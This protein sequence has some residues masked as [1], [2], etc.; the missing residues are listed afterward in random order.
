MAIVNANRVENVQSL[1]RGMEILKAFNRD[2]PRLTLT[3]VAAITGLTRATARRFLI[4][5]TNM[6]YVGNQNRYFYLRPKILELG[7]SY[8]SSLSFND[9]VQQHL[10]VLAEELHESVSA[11]VLEFPDIVYVARASTNRVMTIG[12]SVG[13]KLPAFYTSMG[14]VMLAQLPPSKLQEY[15]DRAQIEKLTEFSLTSKKSLRIEIEKAGNQGW[16]LLDQELEIGLRSLAV[17]IGTHIN[18]TYAAINVS[19]PASRVSIKTL[20]TLILPRL[21]NL[22]TIIDRDI[23]KLWPN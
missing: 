16:Y 19:V 22:A 3:E 2:S 1:H 7:N 21:Q 13:T 12:L 15:L 23:L 6:G 18:D 10:N 8:L 14:R 5:L 20:E 17:P 9:A 11:S 4:T